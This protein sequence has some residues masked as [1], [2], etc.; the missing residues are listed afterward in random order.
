MLS[1]REGADE[2]VEGEASGVFLLERPPVRLLSHFAFGIQE[3]GN[4]LGI[5]ILTRPPYQIQ[6]GGLACPGVEGVGCKV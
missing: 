5:V 3:R 4:S 2:V 1:K 6:L